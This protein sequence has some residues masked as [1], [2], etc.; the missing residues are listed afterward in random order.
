ML[1]RYYA[2]NPYVVNNTNIDEL[3]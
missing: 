1:R 3:N 2:L